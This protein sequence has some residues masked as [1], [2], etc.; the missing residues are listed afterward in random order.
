M[1]KSAEDRDKQARPFEKEIKAFGEIVKN[2]KAMLAQLEATLNQEAFIAEYCRLA[3]A[4]GIHFSPAD[5]AI[6]VQE[7]KHGSQW[8]IPS[9]VLRMISER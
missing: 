3:A 1:L 5:M 2:D 8:V 9:G 4:R 6:S 7:Q